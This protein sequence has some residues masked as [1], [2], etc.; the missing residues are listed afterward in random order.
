VRLDQ[1]GAGQAEQGLGVGKDADD[2][3]AALDLLVQPLQRVG[4]SDLLPVADREAGERREGRRGVAEHG[5]P[6][7]IGGPGM[8]TMTSSWGM[9]MFG[10]GLGEDCAVGGGDHLAVA[11]RQ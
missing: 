10:V 9:H 3:G 5:Q 4:R 7:D 2:I 11:A 8:P 6:A 1:H